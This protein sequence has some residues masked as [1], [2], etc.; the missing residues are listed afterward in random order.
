MT[1]KRKI[2]IAM[3]ALMLP[4]SLI[5]CKKDYTCTCTSTDAVGNESTQVYDLNDQTLRD[6]DDACENFETDNAF[7]TRNCNL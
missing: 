1:T 6:A 5:S 7:V 3:V 2:M 4:V